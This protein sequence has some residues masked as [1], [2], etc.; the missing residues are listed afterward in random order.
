M[1]KP[2]VTITINEFA[3]MGGFQ[4]VRKSIIESMVKIHAQAVALAEFKHPTGQLRN[5]LMWE[6]K[7]ESEGF[8]AGG[9]AES[10]P[11]SQRLTTEPEELIGYVGTNSDHAIYP[12]FG[13]RYQRAQPY[14]RPAAEIIRGAG[15]SEIGKK[16]GREAMAKEFRKR[17]VKVKKIG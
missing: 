16:Y 3:K 9:G 4:G 12:E 10:A 5:T 11:E 13:T 17:K 6:I 15:A 2:S 8:N 14:L 1:A 7:G